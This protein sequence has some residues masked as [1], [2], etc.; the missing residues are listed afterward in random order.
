MVVMARCLG[1][2][3]SVQGRVT[4]PSF[5]SAGTT[6]AWATVVCAE[7]ERVVSAA[8]QRT[9]KNGPPSVFSD[10]SPSSD[11]KEGATR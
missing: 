8:S 7:G 6:D 1:L 9:R 3:N 2:S 11:L 5:S 4:H 10:F